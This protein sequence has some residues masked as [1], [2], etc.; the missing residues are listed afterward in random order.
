MLTACRGQWLA[1]GALAEGATLSLATVSEHLKVLRKTG[2]VELRREG[3]YWLYQSQ[4]QQLNAVLR[5]LAQATEV[6]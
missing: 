6:P 4:P 1:A 2:L 3:R 5:A